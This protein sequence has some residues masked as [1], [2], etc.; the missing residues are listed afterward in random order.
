MTAW[1]WSSGNIQRK[2]ISF[3]PGSIAATYL[4]TLQK[5]LSTY[6][7]FKSPKND[8]LLK[9]KHHIL[10]EA[11]YISC[12]QQNN[13]HD[14]SLFVL[15]TLIHAVD[16]L[17]VDDT[18]FHQD[19][20]TSFRRQLYNILSINVSSSNML[21]PMTSFS[22]QFLLS[23]V[24]ILYIVTRNT[25]IWILRMILLLKWCALTILIM[26]IKC[27]AMHST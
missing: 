7:F 27:K 24:P 12:P 23:F 14:C 26:V 2:T 21:N 15:G 22:R 17:P 8:I 20:I 5:F 10:K 6:S 16:G 18:I 9:E 1:N 19:D 11:N 13:G 3:A 4:L 25:K